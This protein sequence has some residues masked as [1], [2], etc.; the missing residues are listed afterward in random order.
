MIAWAPLQCHKF[1]S[2]VKQIS[3]KPKIF[4]ILD[5]VFKIRAFHNNFFFVVIFYE[6]FLTFIRNRNFKFCFY[7]IRK[8]LT[9]N[10]SCVKKNY[11]VKKIIFHSFF[12]STLIIFF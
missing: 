1:G 11:E 8:T 6:N 7:L 10:F 12:L 3:H 4:K 9:F 2:K 5:Y